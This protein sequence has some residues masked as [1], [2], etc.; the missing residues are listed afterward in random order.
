MSSRASS[1]ID[2]KATEQAFHE[3]PKK[4]ISLI[5]LSFIFCSIPL[6]DPG[7]PDSIRGW[8]PSHGMNLK[9]DQLLVGLSN[10]FYATLTTEHHVG[11]T[12]F[13]TKVLCL[14]W[15][16]NTYTVSITWSEEIVGSGFI[17]SIVCI[18]AQVSLIAS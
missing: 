16:P 8:P 14:G 2:S 7:S 17:Y 15:C 6:L 4:K 12:N 5:F 11:R 1:K 13:S 18:L 10:Y 3:K 9:L